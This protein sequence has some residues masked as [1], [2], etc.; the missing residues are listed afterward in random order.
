LL[1]KGEREGFI[2]LRNL[3]DDDNTSRIHVLYGYDNLDHPQF[4]T[5]KKIDKRI[6]N[7]NIRKMENNDKVKSSNKVGP[8]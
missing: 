7:Y 1:Q 8:N 4:A 6:N 2:N 5:A 3:K